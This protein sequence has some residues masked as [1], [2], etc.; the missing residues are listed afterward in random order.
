MRR[1]KEGPS[2]PTA[3]DQKKLQKSRLE[4]VGLVRLSWGLFCLE[5]CQ[6]HCSLGDRLTIANP[7]SMGGRVILVNGN[8]T[9]AA[10]GS[11]TVLY[12]DTDAGQ[13]VRN[14]GAGGE[15]EIE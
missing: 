10:T 12:L 5:N 2:P 4:L 3:G 8:K 9:P 13:A 1:P 14:T 15:R 11:P 7:A 6:V